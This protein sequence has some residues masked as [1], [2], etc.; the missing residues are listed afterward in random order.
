MIVVFT[1]F[2]ALCA[3]M[4]CL[5]PSVLCVH[6][7]NSLKVRIARQSSTEHGISQNIGEKKTKGF[8]EKNFSSL[9]QY[10]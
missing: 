8:T 4:L 7:T 3:W 9:E 2:H 5:H 1:S 10:E 6:Y